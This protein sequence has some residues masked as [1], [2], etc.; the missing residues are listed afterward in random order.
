MVDP[1][2]WTKRFLDPA[3]LGE[4]AARFG[5]DPMQ[6]SAATLALKPALDAAIKRRAADPRGIAEMLGWVK[7][8]PDFA[9]AMPGGEA[10]G[11]LFGSRELTA[12]IIDQIARTS[13]VDRRSL[14]IVLPLASETVM[15]SF[16]DTLKSHPLTEGL[17]KIFEPKP[18]AA[19]TLDE[20]LTD[21]F[22][23]ETSR[24]VGDTLRQTPNPIGPTTLFGEVLGEFLRGFNNGGPPIDE[25]IAPEDEVP[26]P[27][28]MVDRLFEAGRDAQ[29]EQAR[30]IE[31]LFDRYWKD[32]P[33]TVLT[34]SG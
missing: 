30:A 3:Q 23:P 16:A 4:M 28:E 31:A 14:E 12:A 8:K 13:G 25:E 17:G 34:G 9:A 21:T 27:S 10:L 19:P 22:G 11:K 33:H 20:M 5:L 26:Q 18:R 6:A 1:T 15:A 7:P 32:G 2:E 29:A 24:L